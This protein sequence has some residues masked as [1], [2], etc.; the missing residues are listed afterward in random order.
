VIIG[1]AGGTGSG[2]S[3]I[4]RSL[5]ARVGGCVIDLDSYT[6]DPSAGPASERGQLGD[7]EPAAIDTALLVAQ[8]AELRR[9]DAIRKSTPTSS[10]PTT[11]LSR[12][13]SSGS[14]RS[15]G[16]N[17]STASPALSSSRR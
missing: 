10:S 4:V 16:A 6:L 2:K 15:C 14:S 5:V 13:R 11:A 12:T 7:D 9:G 3:S 8:L 1:L 17:G